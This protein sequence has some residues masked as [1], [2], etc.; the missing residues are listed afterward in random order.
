MII[1]LTSLLTSNFYNLTKTEQIEQ[2]ESIKSMVKELPPITKT[3][4]SF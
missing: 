2:V 3:L 1:H 4:Y